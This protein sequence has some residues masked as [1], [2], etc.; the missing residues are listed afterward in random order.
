MSENGETCREEDGFWNAIGKQSEK[1]HLGYILELA[2]KCSDYIIQR[3]CHVLTHVSSEG[4]TPGFSS[5]GNV[6]SVN[7]AD[8]SN[9]ISEP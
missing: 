3:V 4:R 6:L 5:F 7:L 9:A 1:E 8:L 2:G